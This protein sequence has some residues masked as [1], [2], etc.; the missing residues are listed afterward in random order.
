[1][2]ATG[3]FIPSGTKVGDGYVLWLAGIGKLSGLDE[4]GSNS[5]V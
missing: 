2:E 4:E 5:F 3:D 1:M